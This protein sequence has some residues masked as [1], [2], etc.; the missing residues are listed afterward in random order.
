VR[1]NAEEQKKIAAAAK[2]SKKTV[3]DWARGI[4]MNAMKA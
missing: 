2:A 4:L 3:S 1:I